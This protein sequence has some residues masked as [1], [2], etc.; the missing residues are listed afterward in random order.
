MAQGTLP[1]Q[2]AATGLSV[3]EETSR[4]AVTFRFV[5]NP[6]VWIGTG[7]ILLLAAAIWLNLF[8]TQATVLIFLGLLAVGSAVAVRPMSPL[9][10]GAAVLC[11][12]AT[13]LAVVPEW[14][15]M[16]LLCWL[17]GLVAI[18]GG[19]LVAMPL[20]MRKVAVSFLLLAHFGAILTAATSVPPTFWLSQVI[21]SRLTM[22][23]LQATYLTN[24]YHFYSPQPGPAT[25][26]WFYI[27]YD[28]GTSQWHKI[29]LREDYPVGVEYQRRL[30]IT[31]Y[32]SGGMEANVIPPAELTMRRYKAGQ[33]DGIPM[34]GL[35]SQ[36]EQFQLPTAY[37]KLVLAS[38]ARRVA[39]SIPHPTDPACKVV[40]VKLYR[41]SHAFLSPPA[42]AQGK[43]PLDRYFYLPFFMGEYDAGGQLMNP[44]DPYLYWVIPSMAIHPGQ[45]PEDINPYYF[46]FIERHAHLGDL[47]KPDAKLET[48][49]K[50]D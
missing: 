15:S 30:S 11:A 44:D 50:Q 42:A 41:L 34:H 39:R 14:D 1:V 26:L 48:K 12:F 38:Y 8:G 47:A 7:A 16:R 22:P 46:E 5:A 17:L 40:S 3:V 28:D 2:R 6:W 18:V 24:A 27:T 33:V 25:L 29:P 32:A 31:E 43:D 4:S 37:T 13:Q 19:I 35:K 49:Q 9:V 10:L 23:Y 36:A 45:D 21:F 20:A